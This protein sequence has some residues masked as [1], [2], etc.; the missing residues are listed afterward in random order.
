MPRHPGGLRAG[1]GDRGTAPP[2][3]PP[4]EQLPGAADR[5]TDGP[6]PLASPPNGERAPDPARPPREP[7]VESLARLVIRHRL[8]VVL[9][10]LVLMVAGGAV[11]GTVT[12]RLSFDF[13]L[14]GQPGYE[15]EQQLI[16]TFG[17][18]TADT[19]LPVITVPE[20]STIADRKA[21]IAGVFA[22]L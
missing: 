8:V 11:A 22:A 12:D 16:A 18:S 3:D 9:G 17:T 2:A 10:W 4:R 1:R 21:D 5:P 13:S 20:G 7:S 15:A 6:A 19:L 14:P